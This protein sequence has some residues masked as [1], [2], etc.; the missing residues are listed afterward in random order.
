MSCK[1][2][3]HVALIKQERQESSY[4]MLGVSKQYVCNG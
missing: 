4:H 1:E 3:R 2:L